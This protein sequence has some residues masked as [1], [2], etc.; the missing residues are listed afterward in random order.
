MSEV[1]LA[2]GGG[3]DPGAD[4][5]E[6]K[7][8]KRMSFKGAS[9]LMGR[10][11]GTSKSSKEKNTSS[12]DGG[13]SQESKTDSDSS[14][15]AATTTTAGSMQGSA[16]VRQMK[17][18]EESF[19]GSTLQ[20]IADEEVE[21]DDIGPVTQ[22]NQH[23]QE[24]APMSQAPVSHE[25]ATD[26]SFDGRIDSTGPGMHSASP[27]PSRGGGSPRD[28]Y[29]WSTDKA[30]LQRDHAS[31]K[32][33]MLE[34]NIS[35]KRMLDAYDKSSGGQLNFKA[36]YDEMSHMRAKCGILEQELVNTHVVV[37]KLQRDVELLHS[38]LMTEREDRGHLEQYYKE[39]IHQY[40]EYL[41]SKHFLSRENMSAEL[42][43]AAVLSI[44]DFLRLSAES[45]PMA[46]QASLAA[47][48]EANANRPARGRRP[49]GKSSSHDGE[50]SSA[51]SRSRSDSPFGHRGWR[52]MEQELNMH[53]G[54]SGKKKKKKDKPD[55]PTTNLIIMAE[56][57]D[58]SSKGE[59]KFKVTHKST[60]PDLKLSQNKAVTPWNIMHSPPSLKQ[61][62]RG[63]KEDYIRPV[64]RGRNCAVQE[65]Q[66]GTIFVETNH[67]IDNC[68]LGE[69]VNTKLVKKYEKMGHWASFTS[70]AKF[71]LKPAM[72]PIIGS[73]GLDDGPFFKLK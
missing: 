57:F 59:H 37:D 22:Q 32:A 36:T 13:A 23:H 4:T 17:I 34:E 29:E 21:L 6:K 58:H 56:K 40:V 25:A 72:E 15:G 71:K 41:E 24:R 61:T 31:E 33:I 18:I 27:S 38:R 28:D 69:N 19:Q 20:E 16:G 8:K 54:R 46:V 50:T 47:N 42:G 49:G 62:T 2:A 55:G 45:D 65:P 53:A 73:R 64:G 14:N 30:K 5:V 10:M 35:L 12:S 63:P 11:M 3:G 51:T 52:T 9:K 66:Y 60:S 26:Q 1:G 44:D 39:K 43:A 67:E 7:K 48:T 68:G 70:S